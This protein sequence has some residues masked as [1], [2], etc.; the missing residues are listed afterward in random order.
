MF[1]NRLQAQ[2]LKEA[3]YVVERTN[4]NF[5]HPLW[6]DFLDRYACQPHHVLMDISYALLKGI[7]RDE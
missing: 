1:F 5:D 7:D 3:L 6:D 2:K 4:W